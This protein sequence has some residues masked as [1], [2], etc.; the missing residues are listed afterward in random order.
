MIFTKNNL[1]SRVGL[2]ATPVDWNTEFDAIAARI[3]W[4]GGDLFPHF[5]MP[6]LGL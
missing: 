6:A 1:I 3:D 2:T 5:D 4:K